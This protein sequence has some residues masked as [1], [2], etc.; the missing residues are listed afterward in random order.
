[1]KPSAEKTTGKKSNIKF[2]KSDFT[3]TKQILNAKVLNKPNNLI[4]TNSEY[5]D[6]VQRLVDT[7]PVLER[8]KNSSHQAENFQEFQKDVD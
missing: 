8:V 5:E 1:M 6:I 4:L 7:L 3:N 2:R